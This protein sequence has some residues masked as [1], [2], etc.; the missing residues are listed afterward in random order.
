MNEYIVWFDLFMND[1]F[2]INKTEMSQ[3]FKKQLETENIKT[4]NVTAESSI[5]AINVKF[6]KELRKIENNTIH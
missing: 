4:F 5:E 3:S 1:Y 2:A 6:P